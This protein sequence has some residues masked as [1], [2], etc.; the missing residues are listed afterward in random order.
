M[1]RVKTVAP[2]L[3]SLTLLPL[4]FSLVGQNKMY[5]SINILYTSTIYKLYLS[6]ELL[7]TSMQYDKRVDVSSKNLS[8]TKGRTTDGGIWSEEKRE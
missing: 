8:A 4:F 3:P 7:P 1:L 2:S 6:N 5:R